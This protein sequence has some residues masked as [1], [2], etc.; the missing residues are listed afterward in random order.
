MNCPMN[1]FIEQ[2][3]KDTQTW[4][5]V[6]QN[7][8]IEAWDPAQMQFTVKALG[9]SGVAADIPYK[10]NPPHQESFRFTVI[11]L[12]SKLPQGTATFYFSTR[13]IWKC[14]TTS[15]VR[16]LD[17][18]TTIAELQ[19]SITGDQAD[20]TQSILVQAGQSTAALAINPTYTITKNTTPECPR[21]LSLQ[22]LDNQVWKEMKTSSKPAWVKTFA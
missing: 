7:R 15:T 8:W 13:Y 12:E 9:N 22:W 2:L 10:T 21:V 11:S 16:C 4:E 18:P 3:N 20:V 19:G 5:V 6:V 17:C 14:F 1:A